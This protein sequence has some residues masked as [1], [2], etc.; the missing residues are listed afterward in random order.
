MVLATIL[1]SGVVAA[2]VSGLVV[3]RNSD[4]KIMIENITQ[5]RTKWRNK[6][7]EINKEAH[8]AFLKNDDAKLKAIQSELR[9]LLNPLDELDIDIIKEL[10]SSDSSNGEKQTRFT[11]KLSLLLKHD[12]ER[13]KQE[14]RAWRFRK[15]DK[16]ERMSYEEYMQNYG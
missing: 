14:A 6:F 15:K 2:L 4:R 1:T 8:E 9:L 10:D 3:L 11:I 7:I 16:I 12:W 13:A 5:E